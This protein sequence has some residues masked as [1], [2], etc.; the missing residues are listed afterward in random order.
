MQWDVAV[1]QRRIARLQWR[2]TEVQRELASVQRTVA[3]IEDARLR[4]GDWRAGDGGAGACGEQGERV[5]GAARRW[6]DAVVEMRRSGREA[7]KE[8][9]DL[10]I[11]PMVLCRPPG[12]P[13][14][15]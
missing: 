1:V 3:L 2:I 7:Y 11:G 6:I 8:T 4:R 12:V 5:E 13:I 9:C 14:S 15:P 10:V